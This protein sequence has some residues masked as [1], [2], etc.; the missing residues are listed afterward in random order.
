MSHTPKKWPHPVFMSNYAISKYDLKKKTC[1]T[2]GN[3]WS[4]LKLSCNYFSHITYK[5]MDLTID[6]KLRAMMLWCSPAI[7]VDAELQNGNDP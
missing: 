4:P 1:W 6:N 2:K 3:V 7:L 5:L